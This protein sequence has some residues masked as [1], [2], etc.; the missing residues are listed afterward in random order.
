MRTQMIPFLKREVLCVFPEQPASLAEAISTLG[1]EDSYPVVVLIGGAISDQHAVVT[2]QAIQTLATIAEDINAL[3]I[4]GG[5]DMGV[6]AEIGQARWRNGHKFPLIGITPEAMV[7]WPDGPRNTKFLWWGKQRWML[8]RHYT[9][10]ILVPGSKFGDESS[11]IVDIATL[12]SR[13]HRSVTVLINGGSVSRK[14][15]DLS[16]ANGRPVIA[17]GGTGRLANDL[18]GEPNR[19]QLISVVPAYVEC[20]V[21]EAIRAALSGTEKSAPQSASLG[22]AVIMA[23]MA[24]ITHPIR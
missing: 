5:T 8:A 13:H 14:D 7:T 2:Q 10:F 11:W 12:L 15:I 16:V 21:N 23:G 24:Q 17:L 22:V 19:H 9:H 18:V 20:Q 4:C 3:V 1:L 6:M